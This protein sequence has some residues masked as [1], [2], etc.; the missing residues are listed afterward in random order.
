[1]FNLSGLNIAKVL[2]DKDPNGR[3][4]FFGKVV[5]LHDMNSS[6]DTG[7]WIE[8][9]MSDFYT[10]GNVP[11]IGTYVYVMFQQND[12]NKAVYFGQVKYNIE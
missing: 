7:I 11:P 3:E 12:I 5:G 10:S 9:G 2:D 1:M 6:D 4:R 8:N